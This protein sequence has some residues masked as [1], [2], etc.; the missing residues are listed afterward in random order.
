VIH[1]KY[2]TSTYVNKAYL[3]ESWRERREGETGREGE[4]EGE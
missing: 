3:V 4:S 2:F 1:S